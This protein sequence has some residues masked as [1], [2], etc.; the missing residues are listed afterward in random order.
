MGILN[1]FNLLKKEKIARRYFLMNS[2]DGTL[3]MLGVII[4]LWFADITNP[5]LVITSCLGAGIAILVSGIYSAYATEKAERIRELKELEKHLMTDLDETKIG[6]RFL[7]LSILL[8]LVNGFSP[9]IVSIFI[10]TPFIFSYFNFI[11]IFYSFV[12][13][14]IFVL[15]VL[16]SLGMMVGKIAEENLL[17]NGFKMLSAGILVSII[18][19]VLEIV[20]IV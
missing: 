10:I 7:K 8:A 19:L 9:L 20:K 14:I 11:P 15:F 2:F 13:S 12:L 6:E 17:K 16:F 18:I 1:Y 5:K 3:T 4:A